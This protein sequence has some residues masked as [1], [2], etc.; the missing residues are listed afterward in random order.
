MSRPSS[1]LWGWARS[2]QASNPS[3]TYHKETE[4]DKSDD[5][6]EE[7]GASTGLRLE[8]KEI[9]E[10]YEDWRR[11]YIA[12]ERVVHKRKATKSI[13]EDMFK[14]YAFTVVRKYTDFKELIF[15]T[16]LD[17][18]SPHLRRVCQEVIGTVQG[19]SWTFTSLRVSLEPLSMNQLTLSPTIY[20]ASSGDGPYFLT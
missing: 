17:I 7:G 18:R 19:I 12:R 4:S 6:K 16:W 14:E 13:H 15:T 2:A 9:D 11:D 20:P 1:K 10:I 8:I 3:T 5:D